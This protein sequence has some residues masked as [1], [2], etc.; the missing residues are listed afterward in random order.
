M[1]KEKF[2]EFTSK[3]FADIKSELISSNIN[4]VGVDE[5]L[6]DNFKINFLQLLTTASNIGTGSSVFKNITDL[7]QLNFRKLKASSDKI[8]ITEGVNDIAFDVDPSQISINS[9]SDILSV[10]KGGTGLSTPDVEEDSFIY[11]NHDNEQYQFL[12]L[13]SNLEIDGDTLN[14]ANSNILTT[15]GDLHVRT[16]TNDTRLPVGEDYTFLQADSNEAVGVKW[17]DINL[18]RLGRVA[19]D[20]NAVADY[21][22]NLSSDGVLRT[23]N[24][25]TYT[26]GGDYVTLGVNTSNLNLA[27]A[28]NN[29]SNFVKSNVSSETAIDFDKTIKTSDNNL[30]ELAGDWELGTPSPDSTGS[31]NTKIEVSINGVSYMLLAQST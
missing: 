12:Q 15:K 26:D 7:K 4:L 14:A 3:S 2:S 11:W 21:L 28:N 27:Q 5:N 8:S 16:N 24:T 13:G 17:V 25:L 9:L 30:V 23:N 1:A 31:H 29:T 20:D 19:I 22:G 6:N 10:E 18:H